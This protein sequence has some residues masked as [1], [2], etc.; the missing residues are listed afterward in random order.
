KFRQRFVPVIN[1]I[2]QREGIILD[3][4]TLEFF[5]ENQMYLDNLACCDV[6]CDC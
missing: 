2:A 4:D 1:H 3:E 5:K 6:N